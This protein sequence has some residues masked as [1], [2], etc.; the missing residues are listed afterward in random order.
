[1][2][3][4]RRGRG[5]KRGAM[6]WGAELAGT[7]PSSPWLMKQTPSVCPPRVTKAGTTGPGELTTAGLGETSHPLLDTAVTSLLLKSRLP[8]PCKA[9]ACAVKLLDWGLAWVQEPCSSDS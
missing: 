9:L 8:G 4:E 3:R 2:G 7:F 6:L 1:M 5:G